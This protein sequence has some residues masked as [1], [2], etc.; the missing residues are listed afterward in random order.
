MCRCVEVKIVNKLL[1]VGVPSYNVEKYLG[2]CLDSLID[3]R[4]E[5]LVINDGSTDGTEKIAKDYQARYPGIFR[6][7][8]KPNG[9]WGSGVNLAICEAKGTFFKNLDSDDCF[10]EAGLQALLHNME[11]HPADVMISP[12]INCLEGSGKRTPLQFPNGCVFDEVIDAEKLCSDIDFVFRMHTLAFRTELLQSR[13]I[14]VSECYYADLELCFLPFLYAKTAFVQKDPVYLYR[15]GREGQSMSLGSMAAHMADIE[16]VS[17]RIVKAYSDCG[18]GNIYLEHLAKIALSSLY[19]QPMAIDDRN[20]RDS[21]Y[22][23][24]RTA[25]A[26]PGKDGYSIYAKLV[27]RSGF[28]PSPLLA[29]LWRFSMGKGVVIT[30]KIWNIIR[31]I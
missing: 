26:L 4:I 15:V 16:R 27:M 12:A 31:K 13:D 18:K 9:G 14:R 22:E 20:E 19:T 28:N 17:S 6:V 23:R 11:E 10:D 21:W 5:V 2:K 29:R 24:V 3:D 1:T 7:I 8:S 25:K 30:E